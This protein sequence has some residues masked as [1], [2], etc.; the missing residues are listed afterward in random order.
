MYKFQQPLQDLIVLIKY[1]I[2]CLTLLFD[3]FACFSSGEVPNQENAG[4]QC[5]GSENAG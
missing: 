1:F 5:G 3:L 2:H 4:W